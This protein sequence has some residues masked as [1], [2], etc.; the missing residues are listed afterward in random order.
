MMTKF[1]VGLIDRDQC[2]CYKDSISNVLLYPCLIRFLSESIEQINKNSILKNLF[3]T[4][5]K[6]N[7]DLEC[8]GFHR[9]LRF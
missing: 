1:T 9:N 3:I 5:K 4:P 7:F 8:N 6:Q 2:F